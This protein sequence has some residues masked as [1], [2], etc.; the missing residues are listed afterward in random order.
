MVTSAGDSPRDLPVGPKP[1]RDCTMR[2]ATRRR[3][4]APQAQPGSP[5]R[6]AFR[7]RTLR[8]E[9]RLAPA[10]IGEIPLNTALPAPQ[11][12]AAGPDGA[13]W[14][15]DAAANKIG[16]ITNTGHV[17][18]FSLPTAFTDPR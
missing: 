1:A 11:G 13:L 15:T 16:R 6:N 3:R 12:I 4:W 9:D 10:T 7:P 18:E 14:Y 5:I 2:F 17:S 8:L